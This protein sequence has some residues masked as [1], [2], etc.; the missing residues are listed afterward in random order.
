MMS[1]RKAAKLSID[2]I[3]DDGSRPVVRIKSGEEPLALDAAEKH[4]VERDP[5][6]FQR[7][8][9]IVRTALQEVKIAD[10]KKALAYRVVRVS[11][12]HMRERFSRAVDFQRFSKQAKG[13]VSVSCPK[14]LAQAYLDRVGDWKLPALH[15]VITAPALRW[16][17][18]V[19][20]GR[21]YDPATGIFFDPLGVEFPPVPK[22]PTRADALA[23][24]DKF[25]ELFATLDLVDDVSRSAALSAV[26]TPLYRPAMIAAPMHGITAP[27][28]GSGKSKIVN[29]AAILATGHWAP[30]IALGR[31]E[32][33]AE[34][35]I[36]A[37]LL[38]GDV[39][40]SI[41]NADRPIGGGFLCQ[42]VTEPLI[43]PRI[44]GTPSSQ[45]TPNTTSW[46]ATGNN[47][48]FS[49]DLAAR[50]VVMTAIDTKCEQPQLR[51]FETPDPC[52]T[53]LER[54]AELVVAALTIARTFAL[55][56][57][58]RT[59]APVGSFE[60]WSTWARDPLIWLGRADPALAMQ[61]ARS[62]DP[63]LAAQVAVVEQWAIAIGAECRLSARELA[64]K[65]L[66]PAS[67]GLAYP[68]FF[69]ALL[70]V[71]GAAGAISSGRLGRWLGEVKDRQISG[72]R[73]VAAGV[74]HGVARW[75][76]EALP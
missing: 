37:T 66:Q 33:E 74:V 71:A 43:A 31:S 52:L 54:R 8:D 27:T 19:I 38:A 10:G 24:L 5:D 3:G 42:V 35:R 62:D 1:R 51:E 34:K 58:P 22:A 46:F 56:G 40:G 60:G 69:A 50:R 73:I 67:A 13:Y 41:D 16:D 39:I 11:M 45:R 7:G 36:V 4:L 75:R 47:L 72:W 64:D 17:G 57:K 30:V 15:A 76:L 20:E 9:F 68:E 2:E 53:A 18:T 6:L 28:A 25:D 65:A 23:A 70:A 29:I 61:V 26:L 48:K 63:K 44:L 49:G 55:A 14:D 12:Q 59:E 21:G 32:E